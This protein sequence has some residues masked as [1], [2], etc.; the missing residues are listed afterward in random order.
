ML[1]LDPP[2]GAGDAATIGGIVATGDF[3]PLR[4][5]YG[6]PRDLVVGVTVAL[7]DG[8]VA[9]AGGRVIKNVAGY[10]LAKLFAGSFGTLGAILSVNVRLHPISREPVTALGATSDPAVL[11]AAARA[12]SAAPLEFEGL[13]LAWRGGRGGL[14]ARCAGRESARR[15]RRAARLMEDLGLVDVETST[16]DEALWERQRAGQRSQE[17]ALVRIA[18]AP[19]ALPGVLLAVDACQGTMVGRAALGLSFVEVEPEAVA[20]L[21]EELAPG[22]VAILL[23]APEA[24]RTA[25]DPWSGPGQ[26]PPLELMR[27][28]KQRFDP[29]TTCNRGLFAGGI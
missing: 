10:D 4:H 21:R 22:T 6:G 27:R 29:T 9:R 3:G 14:L 8:T 12:L 15:A 1:A 17:R 28:V 16:E 26:G 18:T 5:R 2:L 24:L 23:D 7:S 20:R 25:L 13:D 11:A 19:T